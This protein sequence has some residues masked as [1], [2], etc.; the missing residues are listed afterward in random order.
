MAIINVANLKPEFFNA[1]LNG[2]KDHEYR[3]R[4]RINSTLEKITPGETVLMLEIGSNRAFTAIISFTL[5]YHCQSN[6]TYVYGFTLID[7]KLI[8]LKNT[9]RKIQGWQRRSTYYL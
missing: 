4:K 8:R 5:R 2:T 6:D 3:E 9:I 1:F 7:I